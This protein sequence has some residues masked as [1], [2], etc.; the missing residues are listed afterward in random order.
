MFRLQQPL[1]TSLTQFRART[2]GTFVFV[3]PVKPS[4]Q[5]MFAPGANI[6]LY[7]PHVISLR[8]NDGPTHFNFSN[9][10]STMEVVSLTS[11]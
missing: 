10:L 2:N 6:S 5:P 9:E 1:L 11:N 3:N 4:R 8:G 7:V